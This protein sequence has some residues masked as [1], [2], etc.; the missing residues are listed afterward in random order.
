MWTGKATEET[1]KSMQQHRQHWLSK[2]TS[3]FCGTGKMMVRRKERTSAKCPRCDYAVEDSK[4]VLQCKGIGTEEVWNK[5]ITEV[6][7]WMENNDTEPTIQHALLAGVHAWRQGESN[8]ETAQP[9]RA[10]NAEQS[11]NKIGWQNI[12]EGFPAKGWA[13]AQQQWY[14]WRKSRRTGKRWITS[15][16]KKLA[17]TSWQ[18]WDHRNTV[19][20]AND[21]NMESKEIDGKIATEF[22]R[23]FH[24]IQAETGRLTKT[25]QGVLVRQS[26]GYRKNWLHRI[27][28]AREYVK[29]REARNQPPWEVRETIGLVEWTKMGKPRRGDQELEEKISD[30]RRR[31]GSTEVSGETESENEEED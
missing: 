2:H 14:D 31:H 16:V 29:V 9:T 17:E 7:A 25:K 15:L 13:E 18:M 28:A 12:M 10:D 27:R 8:S 11:Q 19:N 21:T 4:H 20:N 23:G 22:R 26:L 3:G 24:G 1:M 6:K 30:W 5:H